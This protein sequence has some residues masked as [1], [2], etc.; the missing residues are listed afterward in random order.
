MWNAHSTVTRHSAH[1]HELS[2]F[3]LSVGSPAA[4]K[5]N[6]H[7]MNNIISMPQLTAYKEQFTELIA[8]CCSRRITLSTFQS[9]Q[10]LLQF[11]SANQQ[12]SVES[13][14][15]EKCKCICH[16]DPL[17][18]SESANVIA[19]IYIGIVWNMKS[20]IEMFSQFRFP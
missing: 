7:F 8:F 14:C 17:L 15:C 13:G 12:I 3:H 18:H 20:P 10:F 19:N 5:V 2:V 6:T 4:S 16:P 1:E 11:N 9:I